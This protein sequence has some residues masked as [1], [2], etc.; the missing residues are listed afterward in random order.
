MTESGK[1]RRA[2]ERLGLQ[3]PARVRC[4]ETSALEWVEVTRLLDVTP[5][6][7]RFTVSRPTE[8]GRLLHLS[9]PLPR[10]L[11]V[12]DFTEDQYQTYA[13]VRRVCPVAAADKQSADTSSR[14]E[15]GAAF[16]GKSVPESYV[17]DP[18]TRYEIVPGDSG[19]WRAERKETLRRYVPPDTPRE[20][21]RVRVPVDVAIEVFDAAGGIAQREETV[22]ENI[23]RR[24]M[25]VFSA[26]QI[27]NGRFVRLTS[28]SFGVTLV[29]AVRSRRL[30]A[31][32]IP[33]IHMEF[34]DREFPLDGVG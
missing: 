6:G 34:V 33:R 7:A 12:Y 10:P 30:G 28:R 31:D 9:M 4:R 5:F 13:L 22:T 18:A 15:V 14:F 27:E 26:L 32:G 23:S 16:I 29:A 1:S 3:L 20:E 8:E 19:I 21:T 24:G 2:R 11:R 17:R 25:A